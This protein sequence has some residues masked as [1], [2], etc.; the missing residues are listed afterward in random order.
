MS[1]LSKSDKIEKNCKI[2]KIVKIKEKMTKIGKNIQKLSKI[3][4]KK[5]KHKKTNH[6]HIRHHHD[7]ASLSFAE[8][9]VHLEPLS[10][11]FPEPLHSQS[12]G[13]RP[14]F[15]VILFPR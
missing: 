3:G 6:H 2:S 13:V 10:L 4:F 1:K 8:V 7:H 11:L 9:S 12:A 5:P 14:D 15:Y